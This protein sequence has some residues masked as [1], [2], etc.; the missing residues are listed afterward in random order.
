MVQVEDIAFR[1][2]NIEKGACIKTKRKSGNYTRSLP[3]ISNAVSI[4]KDTGSGPLKIQPGQQLFPQHLQLQ[5]SGRTW[6]LVTLVIQLLIW[7]TTIYVRYV[8]TQLL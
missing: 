8:L 6:R 2:K 4:L 1:T 5:L 3:L 7:W